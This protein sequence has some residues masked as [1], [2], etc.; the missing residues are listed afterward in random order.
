V[1]SKPKKST[2][3]SKKAASSPASPP[4]SPPPT[5][6]A[7]P[8]GTTPAAVPVPATV[9]PTPA[10]APAPAAAASPPAA[11][12]PA[13]PAASA[14]KYPPGIIEEVTL[15]WTD[16]TGAKTGAKALGSNKFYKA[17]IAEMGGM[18]RVTFNY[19]RVGADGQTQIVNCSTLQQAKRT[20]DS[21]VSAKIKKGYTRL[22]MRSHDDEISKAKQNN[23]E[24]T[25]PKVQ[26][27]KSDIVL[28]PEV[29]NLMRLMYTSAGNAI[30]A[31]LSSSAG[32]SDSAPLGNLHDRQLDL[33]ADIL[34]KIDK[35]IRD[36]NKKTDQKKLIDFTNE[37]LSNIPRNIDHARRGGR[38]DI[39]AILLN[40][41]ERVDT[42]RKFISLLR[43]AYLQKD[44]FAAAALVDDPIEVWYEGLNC[45]VE[46]LEPKSDEYKRVAGYF[47]K[48]Q[49]PKNAN[50]YGRLKVARAWRLERIGEKP[51]FQAYA[52]NIIKKPNVTGIVPGWH[53]TRTENLMGISK[54]GLLMPE[55]LPKGVHITG[56]AFGKG[57]YHAPCW[58]DAGEDRKSE[59]GQVYKRYNGALKSMNYTSVAGAYYSSG[60]TARAGYMYLEEI[61]LGVPEVHLTACWDKPRPEPGYDYIYAKA[62]GNP[63]LQHDEIV[64]FTEEASRLTHLLEI[65]T[66]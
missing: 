35:Y 16:L 21:K 18:F 36:S 29:G 33:G 22:E 24:V 26:A 40:S 27:K 64:T 3:T 11:S 48:G 5:A 17:Q 13:T 8:A 23:V 28:H 37:Y 57:I 25:K 44:V 58:P 65:V 34:D 54:S 31:G 55:N 53:G 9:T 1:A 47:D 49:S 20:L 38:L 4:A 46:Y 56:K 39:N 12:P 6:P 62:F 59:D 7:A 63:Q 43:D 52:D 42:E 15:N 60:N 10:A 61:A 41:K 14:T 50:F 45:T 32:A 19:G 2:K 51:K 30:K 66:K